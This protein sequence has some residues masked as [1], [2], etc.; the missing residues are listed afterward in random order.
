MS[1]IEQE[2]TLNLAHSFYFQ[3]LLQ[4]TPT[5]RTVHRGRH[6]SAFRDVDIG[7][8]VLDVAVVTYRENLRMC[9]L[10][11]I[12]KEEQYIQAINNTMS[13]RSRE[14]MLP[15]RRPN[16]TACRRVIFCTR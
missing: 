2:T 8:F 3:L 15:T 14:D 16:C 4:T 11:R 10:T 1:T 9:F 7:I 13:K 6:C 5:D 12:F